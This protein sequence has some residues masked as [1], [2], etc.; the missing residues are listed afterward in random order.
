[1]DLF[2]THNIFIFSL[3]TETSVLMAIRQQFWAMIDRSAVVIADRPDLVITKLAVPDLIHC[4]RIDRQPLTYLS[5]LPHQLLKNP[6]LSQ[7]L[8]NHLL[9]QLAAASHH[10]PS[11]QWRGAVN[12]QGYLYLQPTEGAIAIWLNHFLSLRNLEVNESQNSPPTTSS[13]TLQYIYTR[14]TQLCNLANK[15]EIATTELA[16]MTASEVEL[17]ESILDVWDVITLDPIKFADNN[18]RI[19][20]LSQRLVENFLEFEKDCYISAKESQSSLNFK[21]CLIELV[22]ITTRIILQKYWCLNPLGSW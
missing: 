21:Y 12:D 14:C 15:S 16:A 3:P 20:S 8:G 18:R 11:A 22:K 17:I 10:E 6:A 19:I 1:M 13:I 4:R 2:A 7:L 9:A 5:A